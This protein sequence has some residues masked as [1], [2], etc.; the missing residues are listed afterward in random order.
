[1]PTP[2][3]TVSDFKDQFTREFV[4]GL[5]KETVMDADITRALNEAA[6]V[7]NGALWEDDDEKVTAYCYA[8]AHFLVLNLQA[9][10]GLLAQNVGAGVNSRGGGNV[11]AKSVGSV[12]LT[13]ALPTS[14]TEDPILH[15]FIRTDFG[16]RYL[17][18]LTPRLVGPGFVVESG[19]DDV[20]IADQAAQELNMM[21]TGNF[22]FSVAD[23]ISAYGSV[24]PHYMFIVSD[25]T[26]TAARIILSVAGT[27]KALQIKATANTLNGNCVVTVFKNGVAT[28]MTVTLSAGDLT[29]EDSL[30]Y[31]PVSKGDEISI[32]VD[33]SAASS[34][35]LT[36][37]RC[38]LIFKP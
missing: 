7:F 1:M 2:A 18:M 36:A 32:K 13:F 15:G 17:A 24:V 34:G 10:G 31:F 11:A 26:E 29:G 16:Q 28:T 3:A 4:Y 8:A 21:T 38:V 30:H 5:S 37:L 25:I 23:D 6:S 22:S 33:M 35:A 12:S 20:S 14:L 9:A 19:R 27:I